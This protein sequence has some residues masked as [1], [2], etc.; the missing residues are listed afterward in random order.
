MERLEVDA[1]VAADAPTATI[2]KQLLEAFE[3][4]VQAKYPGAKVSRNIPPSFVSNPEKV[5]DK[6]QLRYKATVEGFIQLP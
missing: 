5:Q 4:E 6:G 2:R 3:T 1:V